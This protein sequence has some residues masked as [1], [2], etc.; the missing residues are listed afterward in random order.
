MKQITIPELVKICAENKNPVTRQA[1]HKA[2]TQ[3]LI[4]YGKKG[5]KKYLD[6]DNPAV[7]EYIHGTNRQR[8][9]V[10]ASKKQSGKPTK[11]QTQAKLPAG[12]QG[13][14]AAPSPDE[15][16]EPY[17]MNRRAK[18]ADMRKRELQVLV[19]EKKYLPIDLIDAVYIKHLENFHAIIERTASTYIQDI[20]KKILEAGEILPEHIEKFT[21]LVLE[22][23]HNNKKQIRKFVNEYE[24]SL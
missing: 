10:A 3:G 4:P 23:M 5:D 19:M 20:G 6:L 21:A 17:E 7:Q 1:V 14:P 24:P 11:T 8:E 22:A 18:F 13:K 9:A 12:K 2:I 16:L 15:N